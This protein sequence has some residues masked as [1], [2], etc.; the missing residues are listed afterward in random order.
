MSQTPLKLI[1]VVVMAI[2]LMAF[3]G[4]ASLCLGL[5]YH[6]YADA[7]VMTAIITIEGALIGY[8]GGMLTNTRQAPTNAAVVQTTTQTLTPTAP[9]PTKPQ[10][11]KIVN[12][13]ESPANVQEVQNP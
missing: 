3:M 11:V 5:F 2:A 8:L 9:D 10:D 7:S 4:Y 6:I 12:P 1:F 13:P